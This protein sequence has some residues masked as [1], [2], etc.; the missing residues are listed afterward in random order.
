MSEPTD[1]TRWKIVITKEKFDVLK[2]K[3]EFWA[4]VA[5]GRAVNELRFIQMPLLHHENDNSPAAMRARYNSLLFSCAIF[6]ESYLLVQK[7]NKHFGHMPEFQD[8]AKVT[9]KS[10]A[11]QELLKDSLFDLRNRLVFHFAIDEIGKQLEN[12]EL[13]EP[14]FVSAMGKTN[15]Q[16]YYE[17]ADLCAARAF[18]KP[19]P[20][21]DAA[22]LAAIAK[23]A[24]AISDLILEFATQA[25]TL[26]VE[27]LMNE[28]WQ[29][30][31]VE[32]V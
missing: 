22:A 5:L 32:N 23:R 16:V 15:G 27:I 1:T 2:K 24:E 26:I 11:A 17:L 12:L 13:S 3:E 28:G 9:S 19:L 8:L 10:K 21:D 4:L 18:S 7:L 14:I 20:E 30:D 29:R 31:V 25:E 6:V